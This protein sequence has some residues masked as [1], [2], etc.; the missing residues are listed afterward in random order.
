[1]VT[2]KAIFRFDEDGGEMI[3][4]SIHPGVTVDEVQ[5][6]VSWP[7]KVSPNLE[8]THSPTAEELQIVRDE[9]DTGGIY[10]K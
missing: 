3:L 2:D 5:A 8:T 10:T 6:D 9:L 4:D 1:M 7:L